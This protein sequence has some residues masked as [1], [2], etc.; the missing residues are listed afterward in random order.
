M[1]DTEAIDLE[2]TI[3]LSGDH[4]VADA[5]I[6]QPGNQAPSVPATDVPVALDPTALLALA[7]DPDTYGSRL[8]EQLFADQRLRDAWRDARRVADGAN[9]PLCVRLRLAATVG[10]LHALRWETLR[11]PLTQVPLATDARLRLVRYPD[12]PD[13]RPITLGTK[14]A[15]R[16][17]LVVA[18]PS[19]LSTYRM[20]EIDVDGEVGRVR[21]A[22][23]D[24]ALMVVGNVEG[25]LHRR[26]TLGAIQDALRSQPTILCL[27][28]HGQH[29]GDDTNL[30]LED[31]AGKTAHV[32]GSALSQMIAQLDRPPL[33]AVLIACVAHGYSSPVPKTRA[34]AS[35]WTFSARLSWVR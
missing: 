18:S 11:D 30:W 5:R 21:A 14:P 1:R 23:G 6:E 15:L 10:D 31:D 22:L 4:Y 3:R 2:L 16:A 19:D 12:S 25:A 32:K 29:T 17:L 8:T 13:T 26:A 20:A 28:C 24:I 7:L 34:S 27:I 33:L 35:A 9:L